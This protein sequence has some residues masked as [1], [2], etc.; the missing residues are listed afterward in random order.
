MKRLTILFRVAA[1]ASYL[2]LAGGFVAYRSGAFGQLL[3]AGGEGET[4]PSDVGEGEASV[5]T[6]LGKYE[7]RPVKWKYEWNP[8]AT[9]S[10]APAAETPAITRTPGLGKPTLISSSKMAV[11]SDPASL[12]PLPQK[13]PA[14]R[15]DAS[16]PPPLPAE[17]ISP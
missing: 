2:L 17:L 14:A 4:I 7:S 16:S 11:L 15:T 6:D 9:D 10:P 1:L 13:K 8:R 12:I 5:P 3:Q